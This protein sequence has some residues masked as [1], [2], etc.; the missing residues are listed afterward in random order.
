[1]ALRRAVIAAAVTAAV[2]FSTVGAGA[3][4]APPR[5]PVV[6]ATQT[7]QAAQV[8]QTA[9]RPAVTADEPVCVRI[10]G[11]QACVGPD[12]SDRPGIT[13]E[14]TADDRSHPAV[15]Y[16]LNGY[17]GTQYVIHNLARHGEVRGNRE[18][19]R[20]VTFR[21]ALYQGDHRVRY[22]RWKTVRNMAKYPVKRETRTTPAEARAKSRTCASTKNA[23]T[24]CFSERK[25][26][27]YA[28]DTRADE[29]QARAEY[30]VGGDPTT[31]FE[32][33]QLAGLGTCG[34]AEHGEL[35][36]SMY[37]ASVYDHS[38]RRATKGYQYN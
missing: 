36:V 13:V 10:K 2:A 25:T 23:A 20:V 19:G 18:I 21:A 29:Y 11:A 8:A 32:I 35:S 3:T 6:R 5:S 34:R 26:F 24:V 31:R 15:E 4:P 38:R 17:L 14:D 12:G 22:G 27:V 9:E 1:M 16:Y 28:C 33:H 7:T 30:F 37:R